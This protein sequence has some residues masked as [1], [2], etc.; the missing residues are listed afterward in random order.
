MDWLRI[1]LEAVFTWTYNI[2]PN[3]LCTNNHKIA[4]IKKN[5]P[6]IL[7]QTCDVLLTLQNNVHR[8]SNTIA[9]HTNYDFVTTSIRPEGV[10]PIAA[11]RRKL[12]RASG[13]PHPIAVSTSPFYLSIFQCFFV[14][15]VVVYVVVV[16]VVA[17]GG[18][19]GRNKRNH[20]CIFPL[21][22][23]QLMCLFPIPFFW[24]QDGTSQVVPRTYMVRGKKFQKSLKPPHLGFCCLGI[25]E[26]FCWLPHRDLTGTTKRWVLRGWW[27]NT[28]RVW[29]IWF[30]CWWKKHTNTLAEKNDAYHLPEPSKKKP[31]ASSVICWQK[32]LHGFQ[33]MCSLHGWFLMAFAGFTFGGNLA[34]LSAFAI[35][36]DDFCSNM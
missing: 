22:T 32:T 27:T 5:Q 25:R 11:T 2:S 18:G 10:A 19:V 34:F 21:V 15:V 12:G 30:M 20:C 35:A 28:W 23:C 36:V 16:V 33:L 26:W 4:K 9:P 1:R 7:L 31:L 17:G 8:L 24:K 14:V 29:L 13:L 6:T 3:K